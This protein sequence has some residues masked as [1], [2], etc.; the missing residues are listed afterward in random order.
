MYV[1]EMKMP[2][3]ELKVLLDKVHGEGDHERIQ[4]KLVDFTIDNVVETED[5]KLMCLWTAYQRHKQSPTK[6]I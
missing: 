5:S 1:S 4:L 6:K 3:E 2:E